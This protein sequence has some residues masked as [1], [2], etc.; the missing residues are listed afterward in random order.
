MCLG[1]LSQV[2]VFAESCWS[3]LIFHRTVQCLYPI[4]ISSTSN[5]VN[6]KNITSLLE[7]KRNFSQTAQISSVE[8]KWGCPPLHFWSEIG[9]RMLERFCIT[10]WWSAVYLQVRRALWL[11]WGG[12]AWLLAE[13]MC[14]HVTLSDTQ[15]LPGESVLCLP[16]TQAHMCTA[17]EPYTSIVTQQLPSAK[18]AKKGS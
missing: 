15:Q 6:M 12:A 1:L 18:R 13:Q 4:P 5:W 10:G 14:W 11:K 3:V 8:G 17:T 2:S 7:G 9:F 16:Q